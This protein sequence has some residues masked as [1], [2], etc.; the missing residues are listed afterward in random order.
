[1]RGFVA[2]EPHEFLRGIALDLQHHRSLQRDEAVLDEEKR[3]EDRRDAHGYEPLITD[4]ARRMKNQAA[5]GKLR[6]K[7]LDPGLEG[8]AVEREPERGNA[9]FEQFGV[10]E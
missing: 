4:V 6:V 3:H 10:G 2:D 1:V 7:L 8:R 9:V 5:S